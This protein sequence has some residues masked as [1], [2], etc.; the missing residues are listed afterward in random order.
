MV[1]LVREDEIMAKSTINIEQLVDGVNKIFNWVMGNPEIIEIGTKVLNFITGALP[2]GEKQ[3]QQPQLPQIDLDSE[4]EGTG[5]TYRELMDLDPTIVGDW[6]IRQAMNPEPIPNRPTPIPYPQP[7]QPT[8]A[9]NPD[10]ANLSQLANTLGIK[11][12]PEMEE[13]T[14]QIINE[15]N[16]ISDE[17][18]VVEEPEINEEE[19]EERIELLINEIETFEEEEPQEQVSEV[20]Q[21]AL[22]IVN[23]PSEHIQSNRRTTPQKQV[24]GPEIEI[25]EGQIVGD[26]TVGF[27]QNP[28]EDNL[29]FRK[30]IDQFIKVVR[31]EDLEDQI[32][33]NIDPF[34][35]LRR[36]MG[37]IVNGG[38]NHLNW[39]DFLHITNSDIKEYIR[40]RFV[41][42]HDR[43]DG[44][45]GGWEHIFTHF[46][47]FR[48]IIREEINM[49]QGM[50][51]RLASRFFGSA[52]SKLR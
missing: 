34:L 7:V 20:I 52:L 15:A 36:I 11:I 39:V 22:H 18:R 30:I 40:N 29:N 2:N 42:L 10:G 25:V 32:S 16:G 35:G 26:R 28:I 45:Q 43:I 31:I 24:L 13:L 33:R 12:P 17:I 46:E 23:N 44:I 4:Y 6:H 21:R 47:R 48:Q 51:A 27:P 14:Q 9:P 37:A 50:G 38:K 41:I 19:Y 5:W 1:R 3:S 49:P 8:V